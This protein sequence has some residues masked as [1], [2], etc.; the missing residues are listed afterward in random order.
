MENNIK[1]SVTLAYWLV[2]IV[3]LLFE[4][5]A[6]VAITVG[7]VSY[8]N[9][10]QD[11]QIDFP[12]TCS[13][14][15]E[16]DGIECVCASTSVGCRDDDEMVCDEQGIQYRST[17]F[18]ALQM[19]QQNISIDDKI[20]SCGACNTLRLTGGKKYPKGITLAKF[21]RQGPDAGL[22]T[23]YK[24]INDNETEIFFVPALN[25]WAIGKS[26]TNGIFISMV[27][28]TNASFPGD[29]IPGMLIPNKNGTDI[30]WEFDESFHLECVED[31]VPGVRVKRFIFTLIFAAIF[32]VTT[33]VTTTLKIVQATRGCL[34]YP[35]VCKMRDEIKDLLL[36]S[37]KRDKERFLSSYGE[38]KEFEAVVVKIHNQIQT[39]QEKIIEIPDLHTTLNI[40]LSSLVQTYSSMRH[41]YLRITYW[42]S[43][44]DEWLSGVLEAAIQ[45]TTMLPLNILMTL[46]SLVAASAS[47]MALAMSGIG[48][49]VSFAFGIVDIVSSVLQEKKVRDQLQHNKNVLN[50]ARVKLD[51][52]FSVMKTFQTNFC[53]FVVKYF[54]EI[55]KKGRQYESTFDSLY[56]FI[57]RIYGHVNNRCDNPAILAY[58]NLTTLKN[59]QKLYLQPIVKKLSRNFDSLKVIILEVKEA[60]AFLDVINMKV[61]EQRR[62]PGSIFRFIKNN[63][64]RKTKEM[65]GN[66]FEFL[67]FIS[68]SVIPTNK[69][70]W[71][72]NLDHIRS[73]LTTGRTYTNVPVCKSNE[74]S[75]MINVINTAVHNQDTICKIH[76]Q[77]QGSVFRNKFQT[78]RFI[79]DNV[80]PTQHCYWGYDLDDIRATPNSTEVSN[81]NVDSGLLSILHN[82]ESVG[83]ID[84]ARNVMEGM[85]SIHSTK[86]Q[87]F[88]LCH[89]WKNQ[90]A[91]SNLHCSSFIAS[92][93][94]IPTVS[95]FHSC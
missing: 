10:V 27:Q 49:V 14:W 34:Y 88:L 81:A 42:L 37:L 61:K 18:F 51:R 72:Q 74:I 60:K 8:E 1:K 90:A 57:S 68:K 19:C 40:S 5:P 87:N 82:L 26:S 67:K 47:S 50:K 13:D 85:F 66:L 2:L 48:A 3:L 93:G 33:A 78:V 45:D 54:E 52:A 65:F 7:S 70:Y 24:S 16:F 64:P 32:I 39:I 86:W 4:H 95:S 92:P 29:G 30:T 20:V 53:K 83:Q 44:Y 21:L 55:S 59:L 63:K 31:Q 80:L 71:G 9:H 17:C 28:P 69:C 73:G 84:L 77:V 75:Y 38:P 76:R 35:S 36:P 12:E 25:A 89:V 62:R 6:A 43:D 46:P 41:D 11:D 15:E 23:R 79:A 56:I 58:S 91:M 22:S 94:C